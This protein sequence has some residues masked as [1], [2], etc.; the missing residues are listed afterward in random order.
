MSL[1]ND[2]LIV[3]LVVGWLVFMWLADKRERQDFNENLVA[4]M[5]WPVALFNNKVRAPLRRRRERSKK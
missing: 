3:W 5:F 4:I 2:V 1:Y